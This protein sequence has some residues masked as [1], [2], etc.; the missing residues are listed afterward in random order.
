M[1]QIL[2]F[3]VHSFS[4]LIPDGISHISDIS[5]CELRISLTRPSPDVAADPFSKDSS[6]N[7][8][9]LSQIDTPNPP[10]K[11]NSKEESVS[12]V[13]ECDVSETGVDTDMDVVIDDVNDKND[14]G[15]RS[16]SVYLPEGTLLRIANKMGEVWARAVIENKSIL[17][18]ESPRVPDS[19]GKSF[20][21]ASSAGMA[22]CTY[23]SIN[24]WDY[25]QVLQTNEA[26]ESTYVSLGS[27]RAEDEVHR[28]P[29]NV[30]VIKPIALEF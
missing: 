7:D 28:R 14:R 21:T 17:I 10:S 1:V 20:P 9:I 18:L 2:G 13:V 19:V 25:W 15:W 23:A 11:C 6:L 3:N 4:L 29:S 22:V 27:L 12:A 24:G 16:K 26:G 8:V 5:S 30:G